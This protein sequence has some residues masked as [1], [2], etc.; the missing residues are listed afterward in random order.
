MEQLAIAMLL[1]VLIILISTQ[2]IHAVTSESTVET[3]NSF[4]DF[5]LFRLFLNLLGYATLFVP[6]AILI[7]YFKR[8]GYKNKP[9]TGIFSRAIKLCIFGNEIEPDVEDASSTTKENVPEEK[10]SNYWKT[11]ILLFCFAGL[12]GSY[13]TWG[14]LQ[15]RIMTFQYGKTE[16]TPGEYFKNSTFLVFLNR[17]SAFIIALIV[18]TLQTQP[19]LTAPLYKCSYSSFSNIMS[20]WCQYEALKFVSFP[21]QV[22]AKASKI[23]PVMLMGKL[24]SKKSYEFYEYLSAAMISIG[25]S[26]FLLTSQ[27]VTK[28]KDSV[29]NFSGVL[30]LVGYMGFDSFTANWQGALF[31]QYKMSSSQM[32]ASVNLFSCLFTVVALIEQGGFVESVAFMTKYPTFIFHAVILSLCSAFGQLF[33]FY[34]ISKFGPVTFTI[35]MTLRQAFAIFLSCII[36]GHPITLLG[37]IGVAV[38]FFALFLRIYCN[39]RKKALASRRHSNNER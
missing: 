13:L 33:I 14:I 2:I 25:V 8:N 15:E 27:D 10:H 17:I 11:V 21:T 16:T 38:V 20:S 34:T 3:F 37:I 24:I 12:Q 31:T 1:Y 6:A 30:L 39:Q 9:V 28:H 7:R 23:I 29:T 18:I 19:R 32:M 36:Y 26:I 5:W 35:I 22:L 4:Y